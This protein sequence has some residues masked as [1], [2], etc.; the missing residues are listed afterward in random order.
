MK[1]FNDIACDIK[2]LEFDIE[3]EKREYLEH[4]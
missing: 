4:E 1:V 2:A 3:F